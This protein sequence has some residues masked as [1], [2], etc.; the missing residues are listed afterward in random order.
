MIGSKSS[1]MVVVF[2]HGAHVVYLSKETPRSI[3]G[4]L[5]VTL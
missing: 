4:M 1:P 2:W 3:E 5:T